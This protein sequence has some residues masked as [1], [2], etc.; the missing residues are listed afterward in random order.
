MNKKKIVL[1][2]NSYTIRRIVELSFSEEE[3]IELISFEDGQ[4]FKEKLLELKPEVVMVD[5]K[6]PEFNGYQV[7]KFINEEESL[8]HTKVFLL[9]GGFE[10]IDENL[11]T[12]LKYVNIITK[13]FDSNALVAT[14]KKIL[15][16]RP[17]QTPP[18]MPEDI[19]DSAPEYLPEIENMP[20]PER[21]IS[22]SDIKDEIDSDGI[23]SD[24]YSQETVQYPE[25][26]VLPSEE[27]TQGTQPEKDTISPDNVEDFENPFKDEPSFMKESPG[28][29][30]EE[31]VDIKKNIEMQ[32]KELKISSITREEIE[33]KKR[34]EERE[35]AVKKPMEPP[36]VPIPADEGADSREQFFEKGELGGS[37]SF[38][39]EK[40]RPM[41]E[42]KDEELPE[43]KIEEEIESPLELEEIPD[44]KDIGFDFEG[45]VRH[46]LGEIKADVPEIKRHPEIEDVLGHEEI[47]F[48]KEMAVDSEIMEPAPK[49]EESPEDIYFA[50]TQQE[51]PVEIKPEFPQRMKEPEKVPMMGDEIPKK[52]EFPKAEK[53]KPGA[54]AVP[55]KGKSPLQGAAEVQE[56]ARRAEPSGIP[57]EEIMSK[58]EDKLSH[59]IQEIL[60]EIVPPVAE[61]I[62]K[63]EIEKLKSEVEKSIG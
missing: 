43:V 30:A 33:I 26:E 41:P 23:L 63:E 8:K 57:K 27:I 49:A 15:I 40:E 12:N 42:E 22:F 6:L 51:M 61:R 25:E 1:A 36:P 17:Q 18:S 37:E 29:L 46:G 62:I 60:W 19:S 59:A 58:V 47:D 28:I 9:K 44:R 50:E 54:A 7:C 16:E 35:G 3:E 21:E 2:D 14:I 20:G 34:L 52:R 38:F 11:L 13:P 10:P 55:P 45:E 4:N 24:D 48:E 31:E 5:I 56:K 39:A 53:E 32:E